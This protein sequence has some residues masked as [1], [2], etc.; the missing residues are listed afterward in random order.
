MTAAAATAA[1][2]AVAA[3]AAVLAVAATA[4]VLAVAATAAVL[5]VAATAAVLAV[6][7]ATAAAAAAGRGYSSSHVPFYYS[8]PVHH[9]LAREEQ[10]APQLR[11]KRF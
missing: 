6:L 8:R 1:V 9:R 5:A 3:T 7:V 2:L 10:Q 11:H 4:A